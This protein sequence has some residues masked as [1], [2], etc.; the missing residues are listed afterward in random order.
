MELKKVQKTTETIQ[1]NVL[2]I[3]EK[4][5]REIAKDVI[6]TTL[7]EDRECVD[8]PLARLALTVSY[9]ALVGSLHKRLFRQEE[10]D[11]NT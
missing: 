4:E 8:S 5:F 6:S 9:A 3:S 10:T 2:T 7:K 11:G 1:E